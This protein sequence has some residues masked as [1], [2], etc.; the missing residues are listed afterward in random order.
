MKYFIKI[1]GFLCLLV[2]YIFGCS[3]ATWFLRQEND[4]YVLLGTI[5]TIALIAAPI[6]YIASVFKKLAAIGAA[7]KNTMEG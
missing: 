1:V 5:L 3:Q 7:G 2:L 4:F 6:A